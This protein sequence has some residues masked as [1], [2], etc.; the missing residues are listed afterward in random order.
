MP[1]RRIPEQEVL[2]REV[3]TWQGQRNRDTVRVN[4]PLHHPGRAYQ[5]EVS[6]PI[7][8]ESLNY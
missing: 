2:R 1:G 7:N 6:L 8:T 5:T 4:W 3:E